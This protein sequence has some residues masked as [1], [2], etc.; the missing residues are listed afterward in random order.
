[1]NSDALRCPGC[2]KEFEHVVTINI[3]GLL[4]LRVGTLVIREAQGICMSCGRVI[5]WSISNKLISRII[6][7]S[8]VIK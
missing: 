4:M 1:M 5:Y 8:M 6:K 7:E 2:E 3:D